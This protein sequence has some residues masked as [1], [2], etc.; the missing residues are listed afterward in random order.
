MAQP[1]PSVPSSTTEGHNH[2]LGNRES[3]GSNPGSVMNER[4]GFEELTLLLE[5]QFPRLSS[6]DKLFP[7]F[8]RLLRD[9]LEV[10]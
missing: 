2:G 1:S 5:P 9:M 7:F 6:G 8:L 10:T 4:N 3:M